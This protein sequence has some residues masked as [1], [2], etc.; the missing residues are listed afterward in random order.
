M[1]GKLLIIACASIILNF[2]LSI[3]NSV[4]AQRPCRDTVVH[5]SD[6][7]CEGAAYHWAGRDLTYSG[8]FYDTLTRA[9]DTCDSVSILH[10]IVLPAIEPEITRYIECRDEVGYRLLSSFRGT[11]Q[12]WRSDPP[13][14]TFRFLTEPRYAFANPSRPTTYYLHTDYADHPF[15]PDSTHITVNPIQPVTADLTVSP[16]SLDYDHT[17][18]NLHD[19]SS[20]NRENPWGGWYG[21]KWRV[22]GEPIDTWL[23][24][25]SLDLNDPYPDSVHISIVAY[26]PTCFDSAVAVIPFHKDLLA[27]ANVFTPDAEINNRF[28]PH[29]QNVGDYHLYIYNRQGRLVFDSA[30]PAQPWDGTCQ[31]S[32]QPQGTYNYRILYTF[33]YSPNERHILAGTVTLLR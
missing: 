12:Q 11:H 10:L 9:H 1:K 18:L 32:P 14:P 25:F 19:A 16:P 17:R 29:L 5:F 31:G 2:Q 7:V 3:I 4:W 6:S 20:G 27:I 24:D 13:D 8:V 21:R 23:P 15:C 28:L 26:T 33:S 22:N 30:D